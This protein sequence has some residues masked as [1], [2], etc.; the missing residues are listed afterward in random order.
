MR[1]VTVLAVTAGQA[2]ENPQHLGVTLGGQAPVVFEKTQ[3]VQL[4]TLQQVMADQCLTQRLGHIAPGVFEQRHQVIGRRPG[5]GVLE[6]QQAAGGDTFA[7]LQ[8]HQVV[9][10]K[11]AQHQGFAAFR[12]ITAGVGE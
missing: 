3:R 10:V 6:I 7:A 12:D 9:D 4:R 2:H 1:Q 5:Q 8:Q 11:V